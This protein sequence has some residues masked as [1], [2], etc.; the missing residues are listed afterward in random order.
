MFL[1]WLRMVSGWLFG[2]LSVFIVFTRKNEDGYLDG[3]WM[4]IWM[5]IG[6]LLDGYL[7]G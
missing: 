3:Y 1:G 5:V 2:W 4:V 7:D 6:W